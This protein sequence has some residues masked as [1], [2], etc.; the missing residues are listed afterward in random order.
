[1]QNNDEPDLKGYFVKA[2]K[3]ELLENA[4]KELSNLLQF[5]HSTPTMSGEL[6]EIRFISGIR[7]GKTKSDALR[8]AKL[9]SV[10]YY[11]YQVKEK[12]SRENA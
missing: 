6:T 2:K 8:S 1:M 12:R 3:L 7:S 11:N 4:A 5:I 9:A 10:D